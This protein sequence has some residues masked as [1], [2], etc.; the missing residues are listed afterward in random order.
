VFASLGTP[1]HYEVNVSED[2]NE[3]RLNECRR[4]RRILK[5]NDA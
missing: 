4:V 2:K 3:S 1:F 5:E